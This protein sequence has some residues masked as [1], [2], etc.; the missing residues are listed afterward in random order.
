ME[1]DNQGGRVEKKKDGAKDSKSQ[2]FK[3]R[4]LTNQQ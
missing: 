2:I 1:V 3:I 4:P